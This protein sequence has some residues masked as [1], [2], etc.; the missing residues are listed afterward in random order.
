M[1]FVAPRLYAVSYS[2]IKTWEL[3]PAKAKY[4]FLLKLPEGESVYAN[5]GTDMH[6]LAA[7]YIKGEMVDV[8]RQL[9]D[10]KDFLDEYRHPETQ[11]E[12]QVAFDENWQPVEW[13]S[14]KVMCRV[15]LDCI[16]RKDAI[17]H[18]ADHKSGKKRDDEYIEQLRLYALACF[19]LWPEVEVIDAQIIYLDH[20]E[21]LRMTYTRDVLP[22]LQEYWGARISKVR[23]DDIFP[24]RPNPKC[25]Y[26]HY[27]KSNGGP[28]SFG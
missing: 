13:F 1:S 18:F 16:L 3:C 23:A 14:I 22:E 20:G 11:T 27:R 7:S 2:R 6:A 8:P 19:M 28:C 10:V 17:V 4:K 12:M 9:E 25:Q 21:R 24:A 5:R 15:I 26:C